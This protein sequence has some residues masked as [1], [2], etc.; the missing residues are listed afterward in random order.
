MTQVQILGTAFEM[1]GHFHAS[2]FDKRTAA[3][4]L[5]SILG[6]D[7]GLAGV[8]QRGRALQRRLVSYISTPILLPINTFQVFYL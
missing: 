1:C 3:D 8:V 4:I 6:A 5:L 2:M 7:D